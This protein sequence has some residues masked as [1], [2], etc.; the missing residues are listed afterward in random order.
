MDKKNHC[1]H[2]KLFSFTFIHCSPSYVH[3]KHQYIHVSKYLPI[4]KLYVK[5]T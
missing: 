4:L 5:Y 1:F 2:I 3:S